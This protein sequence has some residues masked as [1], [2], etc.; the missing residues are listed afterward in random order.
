M[1]QL[2]IEELNK[3]VGGEVKLGLMPPL[4][5]QLEPIRRVIV[6]SSVARPGDVYWA[7]F[8][9]GYDGANTAEEAYARGALGVVASSRRVEP[10]AGKFALRVADA[11]LALSAL[12]EHEQIRRR[13]STRRP[14]A[15]HD[16][17]TT[18]MVA[19]MLR[20]AS[21]S[22]ADVLET[23]SRRTSCAVM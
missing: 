2:C 14:P 18:G 17:D 1:L 15:F 10:W 11:N 13:A 12:A 4:A 23:V 21:V 8:G 16:G 3:I 7:L 22:V 9:H 19:A 20:G 5:G 6:D